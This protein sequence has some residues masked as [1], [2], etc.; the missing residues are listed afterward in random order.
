VGRTTAL[1]GGG[2]FLSLQPMRKSPSVSDGGSFLWS[3]GV[4]WRFVVGEFSL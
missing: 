2:Y 1:G 3:F 4:L